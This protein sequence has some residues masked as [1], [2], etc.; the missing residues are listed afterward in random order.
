MAEFTFFCSWCGKSIQCDVRYA[1]SQINCPN[2]QQLVGVPSITL[3]VATPSR[4]V[5]Q[6]KKSTIRNILAVAAA[7]IV[8]AGLAAVGWH[9]WSGN[10]RL[11]GDWKMGGPYNVGMPCQVLQAGDGLTFVNENG[12][13]FSG[14]FITKSEVVV[15]LNGGGSLNGTLNKNA[16]RINWANGTWWI[17]AK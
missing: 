12:V 8:V 14:V 10:S 7:I 2:C 13:R 5:I 4:E 6:I 15:D 3:P 17:R 16:T 11:A 1:G 9:F